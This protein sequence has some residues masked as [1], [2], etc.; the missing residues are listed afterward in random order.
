MT[1][2]RGPKRALF[3]VLGALVGAAAATLL[4]RRAVDVV[5]VHGVSM[6]P[7]LMPGDRLIVEALSYR[8]RLPRQ[9]EIVLAGDPREPS[10]ELVKRIGLVDA[11][12]GTAQLIGDATEASTDSRTFGPIPIARLQWRVAAR[13]WPPARAALAHDQDD[14]PQFFS[15]AALCSVREAIGRRLAP[16]HAQMTARDGPKRG[17]QASN[18][19]QHVI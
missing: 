16:N 1:T 18:A 17:R 13:Y 12:A 4:S 2:A 7:A 19:T 10:R 8:S 9:G 3:L 5:E 15:A 14:A 6:V 11:G